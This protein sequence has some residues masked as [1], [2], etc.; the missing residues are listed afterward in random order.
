MKAVKAEHGSDVSVYFLLQAL[1][2]TILEYKFSFS[3]KLICLHT[4]VSHTPKLDGS[5]FQNKVSIFL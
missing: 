3:I 4:V 1:R 5:A 2:D